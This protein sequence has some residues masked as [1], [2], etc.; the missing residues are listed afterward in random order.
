MKHPVLCKHNYEFAKTTLEY[1]SELRE[2]WADGLESVVLKQV[3]RHFSRTC[4][5]AVMFAI[6]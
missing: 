1:E 6:G 2:A 3:C 4:S 5:G